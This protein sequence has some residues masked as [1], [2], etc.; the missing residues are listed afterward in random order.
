MKNNISVHIY[1]FTHLCLEMAYNNVPKNN[2][3]VF[4]KEVYDENTIPISH[5]LNIINAM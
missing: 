3:I 5:H 1:I 2:T 4:C